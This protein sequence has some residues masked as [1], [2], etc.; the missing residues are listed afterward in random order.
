MQRKS[1]APRQMV[2]RLSSLGAAWPQFVALYS[3]VGHEVEKS[4]QRRAQ[5]GYSEFLALL[6]L[7]ENSVGELRMQELAEATTL[8]QSSTSRLVGRLE[9]TGLTER[10]LCEY[11]RR[12][13]YTGITPAGR[14]A[15]RD[16]IPVYE[17]ALAHALDSAAAEPGVKLLL[18]VMNAPTEA[19]ASGD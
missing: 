7:A 12:G 19:V 16:A 14:K 11:D 2:P 13:V 17:A 18:S 8:N 3:R 10:R 1:N 15:L 6:A 5:L 4:L 9:R